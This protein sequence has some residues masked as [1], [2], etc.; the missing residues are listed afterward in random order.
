MSILNKTIVSS[1]LFILLFAT[2][3][4]ANDQKQK[5]SLVPNWVLTDLE[6][7][8]SVIPGEDNTF[9]FVSNV[10]GMATVKDGNGYISKVSLQGKL[11][12]RHWF[13][14]L[15]APKGLAINGS[16]LYVSDIDH[17]VLINTETGKLIS[18][19]EIPDAVFLNDVTVNGSGVLISDSAN[20]R[21][22]SF[23]N[24]KVSIWLEDSRLKGVNGLLTQDSRLLVT[25]MDAGELLSIDW[26]NKE[27]SAI[28]AGMENADGLAQ[29]SDNSFIVSAWT[30]TLYHISKQGKI[31]VLLDTQEENINQNDFYLLGNTIFVA[32]WQPG[33]LSAYS[34]VLE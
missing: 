10:N 33:S 27:I 1:I 2:A 30:G 3:A 29:L 28:S 8:E 32:N 6:S 13:T 21:I 16:T 14:G 4:M 22:Y 12:D 9:L 26:K 19:I 20:A 5:V 31:K 34:V 25:T 11:L 24:D 17:L 15:N 18:K 7:P 23:D